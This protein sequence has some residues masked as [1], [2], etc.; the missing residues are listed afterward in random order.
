MSTK[1]KWMRAAWPLERLLR[2]LDVVAVTTATAE[3]AVVYCKTAGVPRVVA[4]SP[5]RFVAPRRVGRDPCR[6]H[7]CHPLW[8]RHVGYKSV[9]VRRRSYA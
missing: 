9:R 8:V 7:P 1:S 6:R 4:C 5:H 3:A 2:Q